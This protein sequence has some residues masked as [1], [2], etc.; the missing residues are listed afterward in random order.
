MAEDTSKAQATGPAKLARKKEITDNTSL[1]ISVC[2]TSVL[3]ECV[4]EADT[5]MIA[6][7]LIEI[8]ESLQTET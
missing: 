2:S 1:S 6:L 5:C 8:S 3:H 7:N 4:P